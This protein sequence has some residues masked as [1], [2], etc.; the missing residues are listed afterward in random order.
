MKKKNRNKY[1]KNNGG[2]S[3]SPCRDVAWK[4]WDAGYEWVRFHRVFRYLAAHVSFIRRDGTPVP[5]GALAVAA[6]SGRIYCHPHARVSAGEWARA[7]AHCLLHFAF[8]HFVP[9][10]DPAAWNIACDCAAEKFLSDMKFADSFAVDLPKLPGEEKLYSLLTEQGLDERYIG[11]GTAGD[12]PDMLFDE[13]EKGAP[14]WPALF[15]AGLQEAVLYALDSAAYYTSPDADSN[16]PAA[17]ARAWFVS[18]YPLLGALAAGFRLVEDEETCRSLNIQIAAVSCSLQE[19]YVNPC[20]W[21]DEKESLFVVAHE[22]LHAALRH[23]ARQEW[24]DDWLWNVACDFVVNGWLTEMEIGEAP[25]GALLDKEFAGLSAEEVYDRVAADQRY[26]RSMVTL[27]GAALGDILPG[28]PDWWEHG[29]GAETDEFYRRALGQ[30][31]AWHEEQGRGHLPE[32]LVEEIRALGYP[33]IPWDVELARWFDDMF[34]P[35]E[36]TRSYARASRRQS[37]TPDIPRPAWIARPDDRRTF[38]VVLDTSGSMDRALLAAALGAIASYSM[39]RD[40]TAARVVFCDAA[41]YDQG[42]MPPEEIAG[43]VKVRG[44]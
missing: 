29:A 33:P 20:A 40:V 9:H 8:G 17:R 2:K 22:L 25:D 23:D 18:S 35:L 36:K 7:L 32:G 5:K 43:T 44:R 31:L 24:R 16:S 41:A 34:E 10:D 37:A 30:G 15:A 28:D 26:Y 14:D 42:Y 11:H 38:G 39:A 3:L 12:R 4:N 1:K 19:I 21:L 27:R 6:R 13:E